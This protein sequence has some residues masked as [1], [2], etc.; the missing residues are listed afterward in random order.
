MTNL[1]LTILAISA[2]ITGVFL[3]SISSPILAQSSTPCPRATADPARPGATANPRAEGL[4]SSE[5]LSGKFDNPSGACVIDTKSSFTQIELPK[6]YEE[7][8]RNYYSR[9]KKIPRVVEIY[10]PHSLP[11]TLTINLTTINGIY[12]TTASFT[13]NTVTIPNTSGPRATA[14]KTAVVFIDQNLTFSEDLVYARKNAGIVFVVKGD[15]HINTS[16]HKID[17][18]IISFGQICTNYDNSSSTCLTTRTA[19]P[20]GVPLKIDGSLISLSDD[21]IRDPEERIFFGRVLIEN[22]DAAEVINQQPKFLVILRDL[23]ASPLEIR[24][25]L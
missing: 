17:A 23:F 16:V 3:S 15:V 22:K 24:T 9:A 25:E 6:K 5:T 7:V 21:D 4:I 12:N 18:V 11:A 10:D 8:K 1:F 13:A 2:V 14:T 20:E 19:L